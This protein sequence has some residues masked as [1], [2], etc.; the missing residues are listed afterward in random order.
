MAAIAAFA[1]ANA[2]ALTFATTAISA[3]GRARAGAARQAE[4][5]AQ[6]AQAEMKGRSEAIAYKQQS[7]DV[8]KNLNENLAATIA[9]AGAGGVVA[10]SGSAALMQQFAMSEGIREKNIASDNA[11]LAEGQASAQAHQYRVAGQNARRAGMLN[12]VTTIGTGIYRVGQ[13]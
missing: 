3:I 5:N 4:Y 7:A 6:A 11:L 1:T 12:A 13:L 8:L 9:R 10:E 2:T